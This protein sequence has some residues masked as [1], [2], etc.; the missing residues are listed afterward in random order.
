MYFYYQRIYLSGQSIQS[1]I[2]YVLKK[3]SLE[4]GSVFGTADASVMST[5]KFIMCSTQ[6]NIYW[7]K[8]LPKLMYVISKTISLIMRVM[9]FGRDQ[10]SNK[11]NWWRHRRSWEGDDSPLQGGLLREPQLMHTRPAARSPR[12]SICMQVPGISKLSFWQA[13]PSTATHHDRSEYVITNI[14]RILHFKIFEF[15]TYLFL[16]IFMYVQLYCGAKVENKM[17]GSNGWTKGFM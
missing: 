4:T 16:S 8:I 9:L 11:L 10:K 7:I 15:V 12:P 3:T 13:A 2:Y 17:E 14:S 5:R 1:Q 6:N